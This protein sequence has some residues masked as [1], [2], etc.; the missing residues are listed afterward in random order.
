[1]EEVIHKN[2][3]TKVTPLSKYLAMIL[4]IA[5]PFIG[6]WVGYTYAPRKIVEIEKV[7]YQKDTND[8]F[9]LPEEAKNWGLCEPTSAVT[10]VSRSWSNLGKIGLGFQKIDDQWNRLF[11]PFY[12]YKVK[13]YCMNYPNT[14]KIAPAGVENLAISFNRDT[15]ST[16]TP[17]FY[18]EVVSSDLPLESSDKLVYRYEESSSPL[19]GIN[20]VIVSKEIKHIGDKDALVLITNEGNTAYLRI[21]VKDES[22]FYML[23]KSFPSPEFYTSIYADFLATAFEMISSIRPLGK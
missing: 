6:G 11:V 9:V 4:F 23:E 13:G 16:A 22:K 20:E 3:F 8:S 12:D 14:W 15:N 21:F 1:M 2:L 5:M 17:E 18:F 10:Q 19:V 7:V